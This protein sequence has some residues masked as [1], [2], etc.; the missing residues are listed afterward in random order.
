MH[1]SSPKSAKNSVSARRL[2]WT[3][4]AEPTIRCSPQTLVS[5]EG[6]YPFPF[7]PSIRVFSALEAFS[8]VD[9]LYKLRHYYL[10][11][12]FLTDLLDLGATILT[13]PNCHMYYD[14]F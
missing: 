11:T 8:G 2:P 10:A 14:T 5:C 13:L 9:V 3:L 1:F 7:P 4:L 12:C 6:G